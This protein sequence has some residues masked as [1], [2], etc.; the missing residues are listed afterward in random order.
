MWGDYY[1]YCIDTP[2]V[3]LSWRC[4]GYVDCTDGSDEV[5]CGGGKIDSLQFLHEY[6]KS[7]IEYNMHYLNGIDS[8]YSVGKYNSYCG[9]T[10]DS[11]LD[12]RID[13]SRL[14]NRIDFCRYWG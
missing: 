6:R 2:C 5:Q 4:D 14:D 8:F 1:D 3:P 10:I 11:R 12:N 13:D 9:I 7:F